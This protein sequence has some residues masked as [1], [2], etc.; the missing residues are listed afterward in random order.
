MPEFKRLIRGL[1]QEFYP[2]GENP[3]S[4]NGSK[5]P[6]WFQAE[7]IRRTGTGIH[8]RVSVGIKRNLIDF[9]TFNVE[10]S[11]ERNSIFKSLRD[12]WSKDEAEVFDGLQLHHAFVLFCNDLWPEWIRGFEPE[13]L[14][15]DEYDTEIAFRLQ[16]YVLDG[17]GTIMFGPPGSLK[18]WLMLLMLQSVNSGVNTIWK[19][20]QGPALFINLERDASSIRRR[21]GRVNLALGLPRETSLPTI[22]ARGR[23]LKDVAEIAKARAEERS[24][25]FIGLDSIS[26]S[27][28][29]ELKDGDPA[30]TI[31]DTLAGICPTWLAIGH[32]PKQNSNDVY[33]STFFRAGCD[34]M[35]QIKAERQSVSVHGVGLH[36]VK[37]NDVP[38]VPQ[39][40]LK[41]TLSEYGLD[42]V[43]RTT[44]EKFP[45]TTVKPPS[46]EM[47]IYDFL[48]EL[49][50]PADAGE[51]ASGIMSNRST[52]S[53]MLNSSKR[54]VIAEK[55]G[56][57]ALYGTRYF[58][59][60]WTGAETDRF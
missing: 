3:N 35:V 9:D 23:S 15:G 56:R 25:A 7:D 34:V 27:G 42:E 60:D 5:G 44:S 20:N 6:V 40:T 29:G 13:D 31:I 59:G 10:R 36:I 46:L 50:R 8:A 45:G 30:N 52:V 1:R 19:V 53:A 11:R 38:Y 26:R 48:N 32:P 54:F 49:R 51:I 33:G 18:S 58:E 57:K 41:A 24:I 12:S 16:P 28:G 14:P 37:A 17:G 43:T 55:Q 4:E 2:I 22:N 21:L 39:M 47:Q